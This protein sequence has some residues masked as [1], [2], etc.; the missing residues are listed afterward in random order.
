MSARKI[1]VSEKQKER[2]PDLINAE[3]ALKRA[4]QK[5]RLRAGQA[6]IGVIVVQDG[7]IIE[8][9]PDRPI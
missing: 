3:V 1:D 5:A 7:R 6:G 9:Q 2:D 4:A 8:E